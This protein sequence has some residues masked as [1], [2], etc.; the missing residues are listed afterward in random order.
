MNNN[1]EKFIPK[2]P[3]LLYESTNKILRNYLKD[4]SKENIQYNELLDDILSLLFYFKIP[5]IEEKWIEKNSEIE[6][7]EDELLNLNEILK[8]IIAILFNLFNIIIT[9]NNYY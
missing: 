4:F 7:E 1:D 8:K 5:V 2:V 9:N 3:I 6:L